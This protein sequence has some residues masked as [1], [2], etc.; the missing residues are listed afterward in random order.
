MERIDVIAQV[1]SSKYRI[2]VLL[3]VTNLTQPSEIVRNTE[4]RFSHV[5]RTLRELMDLGL[6]KLLNPTYKK[7]RLYTLTELGIEIK[8]IIRQ[9]SD[10]HSD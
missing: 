6:I 8:T 4:L 5:S 7:G 2:N 3:Q 1:M 9:K 10:N